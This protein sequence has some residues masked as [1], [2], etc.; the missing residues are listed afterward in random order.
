MKCVN[1]PKDLSVC[2]AGHHP[3]IFPFIHPSIRLSIRPSIHPSVYPPLRRGCME[4]KAFEKEPISSQDWLA[5]AF[6]S[7][8]LLTKDLPLL[9]WGSPPHP[10]PPSMLSRLLSASCSWSTKDGPWLSGHSRLYELLPLA[11]EVENWHQGNKTV[12]FYFPTGPL[13][14]VT[15]Y[16]ACLTLICF[17]SFVILWKWRNI[18]RAMESN[19]VWWPL[20]SLNLKEKNT[21]D[22]LAHSE[23][24]QHHGR[25]TQS[26]PHKNSIQK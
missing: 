4:S 18:R 24:F 11:G 2:W 25:V 6:I 12:M 5:A 7:S 21:S 1:L 14:A 19:L 23:R 8:V 3:S 22:L 9:E 16:W 26:Y 20:T 17:N 13:L 15:S 10:P